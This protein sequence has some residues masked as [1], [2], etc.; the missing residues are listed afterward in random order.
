MRRAERLPYCGTCKTLGARYGQRTRALLNHDSVFLAELLL[1]FGGDPQ[2][3]YAYRSFNCL[4]LPK[5]NTSVPLP[6]EYAAAVTVLLARHHIADQQADT[7]QMRW[8]IAAS[9][10]SPAWRRAAARLRT[11]RFPIDTVE[12]V[13]GT[14]R[15]R[16]AAAESLEDVA[17]PTATATALVF[18]HGACMIGR[19]DLVDSMHRLGHRFGYLVYLLDAFEDLEK[20][21]RCGQ[22]NPLLAFPQTPLR[23]EILAATAELESLLPPAFAVRL[24]NNVEERLGLRFRVLRHHCVSASRPRWRQ[25]ADT[26]RSIRSRE[27]ARGLKAAAIL[28]SAAGIAFLFPHQARQ[29]ESWRQCMGAALNVMAIAATFSASPPP[30][31]VPPPLPAGMRKPRTGFSWCCCD[32]GCCD[33]CDCGDCGCCDSCDCG[34]CCSSC[35]CG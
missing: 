15:A 32:G 18:S 9:M 35:D 28:A 23:E 12:A 7:S 30:P 26:A 6:L 5:T 24:R 3:D 29:A 33:G 1:H 27:Q 16:E 17:E 31:P 8:R 25:A 21:R 34:S 10:L 14:Q 20:D 22:F 11:W 19:S 2:W 13:L 4:T